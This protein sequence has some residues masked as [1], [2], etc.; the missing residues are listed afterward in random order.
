MKRILLHFREVSIVSG[1]GTRASVRRS[2]TRPT[3]RR[4]EHAIRH[5]RRC[6]ITDLTGRT[7]IR[8]IRHG[9]RAPE[10]VAKQRDKG[11]KASVGEIG[12][13]LT[14]SYREEHLF[15]LKLA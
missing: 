5:I 12:E 8:A 6:D 1:A 4:I 13:A 9:T 10:T 3:H 2:D 15:E 7:I 11:C 14:G